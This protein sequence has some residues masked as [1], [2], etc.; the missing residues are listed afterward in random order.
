[1]SSSK[2]TL[3]TTYFK[4]LATVFQAVNYLQ[5]CSFQQIAEKLYASDNAPETD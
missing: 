3:F 2:F 5:Q 1:M 4:S